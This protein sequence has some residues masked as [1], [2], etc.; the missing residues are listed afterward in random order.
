MRGGVIGLIGRQGVGK[1]SALRAIYESRIRA[2]EQA[3]K[4]DLTVRKTDAQASEDEDF[5]T[6]FFKWQRSES[7]YESLLGGASEASREFRFVYLPLLLES[8]KELSLSPQDRFKLEKSSQVDIAW[9]EAILGK[10]ATRQLRREAWLKLL[11]S[12]KAILIDTPDYSKTDR[13]AMTKDLEEIC[14]LWNTIA[15]NY[16]NANMVVAIQKEMFRGHFFLDK[17]YK[18]ELEPLKPEEML[19]A[20]RKALGTLEP[21]T[22]EALLRLARMSRGVFRRFLR[23]ITLTLDL[24]QTLPELTRFV[25]AEIVEKAIT[26]ERLAEDMELELLELFPKNKEVRLYAVQVLMHLDGS[27]P[28]GQEALAEEFGIE[29][30]TMSRLLSKLELHRYVTRQRSETGPDKIVSLSPEYR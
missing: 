9:S 5:H 8:V 14:W 29:D 19:E 23:Y 22:S 26:A 12:K 28:T 24:L 1:S 4:K 18:I 15:E 10:A 2:E 13:R 20:Y 16:G 25:D 27:G 17:M 6:I 11:F 21:F 7:L 30:Y 3:R